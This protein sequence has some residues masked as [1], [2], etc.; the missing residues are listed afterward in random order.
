MIYFFFFPKNTR[1][2][3][4][5]PGLGT[6]NKI[7][8]YTLLWPKTIAITTRR[9]QHARTTIGVPKH[10]DEVPAALFTVHTT[11]SV[12]TYLDESGGTYL[13][14]TSDKQFYYPDEYI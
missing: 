4:S 5:S 14:F 7:Y 8:I 6:H 1:K 3:F 11:I 10:P 12:E 9:L 13:V 2:R